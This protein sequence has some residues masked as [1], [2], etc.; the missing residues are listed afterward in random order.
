MRL[1]YH[2]DTNT[3]PPQVLLSL[4][5]T[6]SSIDY[7]IHW[8]EHTLESKWSWVALMAYFG[9]EGCMT[10]SCLKRHGLSVYLVS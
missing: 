4:Y 6:L 9:F 2:H 5:M 10:C 8:R 7:C 1:T 3:M